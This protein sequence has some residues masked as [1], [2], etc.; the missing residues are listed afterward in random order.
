MT[1]FGRPIS[2]DLELAE[3]IAFERWETDLEVSSRLL[4]SQTWKKVM[5]DK[6]FFDDD[7][8]RLEPPPWLMQ[9]SAQYTA[10]WYTTA[11]YC[12]LVT[13]FQLCSASSVDD[14]ATSDSY[15]DQTFWIGMSGAQHQH[16]IQMDTE[17]VQ[18]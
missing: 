9:P 2:L 16:P 10:N 15:P 18:Q 14:P 6:W 1:V 11:V 12:Y 13:I 17:R 3:I 7:I 5:A 4:S 8:L